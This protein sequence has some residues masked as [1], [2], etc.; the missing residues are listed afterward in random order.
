MEFLKG[1]SFI[2]I[3]I[4]WHVLKQ[5]LL[6]AKAAKALNTSLLDAPTNYISA[7]LLHTIMLNAY[8][9]DLLAQ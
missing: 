3:D 8:L 1:H 5:A 9:I 2:V 7:L 4:S 6:S